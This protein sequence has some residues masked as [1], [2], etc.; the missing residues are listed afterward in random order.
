MSGY[1]ADLWQVC[2]C[3][4]AATGSTADEVVTKV[5]KHAAEAHGMKEVPAEIAQKLQKA[6][7]PAM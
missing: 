5:K 1:A 7:R 3:A 6:I 4:W 2:G